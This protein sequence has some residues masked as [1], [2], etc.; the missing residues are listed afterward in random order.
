MKILMYTDN[1]FSRATSTL[2][3][4]GKDFSERLENQI[5]SLNWTERLAK[6]KGCDMIICLGDFFDKPTL[7]DEEVSALSAIEWSSIKHYFLVGN[8]ESTISD[9]KFSTTKVLESKTREI[10][11]KVTKID[12]GE[13]YGL[14]FIPYFV[15]ENLK[16][17]KEY[18]TE[19]NAAQDLIVLSHNDIDGFEFISG[20]TSKAGL[21]ISDIEKNCKLLFNGH[22]HSQS[23]FCKNGYNIGN[24]TG[25]NF[26]EDSYKSEHSAYILTLEKDKEPLIEIYENPYAYNF[27]TV[28]IHKE[29]DIL[30]AFKTLKT[31]AVVRFNCE[32]SLKTVLEE[33]IKT[34]QNTIKT[35]VIK[36]FETKACKER[37]HENLVSEVEESEK[38]YA[39]KFKEFCLSLEPEAGAIYKEELEGVVK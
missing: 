23:K 24:L 13:G 15:P 6:E 1:H 35:Y 9:L 7:N 28:T 5:E 34:S 14:L 21:N 31:N 17:I 16:S 30:K 36:T 19:A 27:Y 25:K 32:V 12:S 3:K 26:T 18:A 20:I 10:I 33:A 8:H 29:E 11:S 38:S 37:L 2:N 22:I 39:E 4:I